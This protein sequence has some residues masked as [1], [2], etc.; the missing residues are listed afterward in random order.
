MHVSE[1]G[2]V[3][4]RVR[5]SESQLTVKEVNIKLGSSTT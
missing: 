2:L 4:L 1:E 3:R 5:N